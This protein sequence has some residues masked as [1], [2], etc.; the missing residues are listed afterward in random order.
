MCGGFVVAAPRQ[1]IPVAENQ[2]GWAVATEKSHVYT[3]KFICI[4]PTLLSSYPFFFVPE[5]SQF[6][7]QGGATSAHHNIA[8][9]GSLWLC[10]NRLQGITNPLNTYWYIQNLTLS[11][12]SIPMKFAG[13]LSIASWL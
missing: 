1:Q 3:L 10:T 11:M 6:E 8:M 4:I 7:S 12:Y 9:G 2:E 13:T 5:K